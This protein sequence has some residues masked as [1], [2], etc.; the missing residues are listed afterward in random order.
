MYES[1]TCIDK[2]ESKVLG[3]L[4]LITLNFWTV[5]VTIK[6]NQSK[7]L[8]LFDPDRK[9]S[10]TYLLTC[11]HWCSNNFDF[12]SYFSEAFV[13]GTSQ[14]K[15]S[16]KHHRHH[17]LVW[18]KVSERS[19]KKIR[20]VLDFSE[21]E[22]HTFYSAFYDVSNTFVKANLLACEILYMFCR[23]FALFFLNTFQ[24][25]VINSIKPLK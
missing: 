11:S 20:F 16:Q 17:S 7:Q 6:G 19:D 10:T 5:W 25:D 3:D 14:R 24:L 15:E 13:R 1:M 21:F 18:Y 2:Q 12:W 22:C 9:L 23:C 4:L 8:L